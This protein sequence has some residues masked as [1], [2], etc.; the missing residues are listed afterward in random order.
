MRLKEFEE[1]IRECNIYFLILKI[2][3]ES[4]HELS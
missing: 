1:E 3:D 4:V 2:Y